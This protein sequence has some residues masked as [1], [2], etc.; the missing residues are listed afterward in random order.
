MSD[1]A[2]RT[3]MPTV[4]LVVPMYRNMDFET[5]AS[6][7]HLILNW[8]LLLPNRRLRLI[9]ALGSPVDANRNAHV[10]AGLTDMNGDM[11]LDRYCPATLEVPDYFLWCDSDCYMSPQDMA[12]LVTLMDEEPETTG[13]IGVVLPKRGSGQISLNVTP[14]EADR[15]GSGV[16][17]HDYTR[18]LLT[19][20]FVTRPIVAIGAGIKIVRASVYRRMKE[21]NV[22]WYKFDQQGFPSIQMDSQSRGTCDFHTIGEDIRFCLEAAKLGFSIKAVSNPT[23]QHVFAQPCSVGDVFMRARAMQEAAYA[24]RSRN[25]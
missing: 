20:D 17:S 21:A 5:W 23:A 4:G 18:W 9:T 12:R 15:T 6:L 16:I 3:W 11:P 19:R 14:C 25:Q 22:L 7:S 2:E 8:T 10:A 13:M 24:A 1:A